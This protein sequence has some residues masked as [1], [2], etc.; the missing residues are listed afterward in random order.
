M[1]KKMTMDE[2]IKKFEL[3]VKGDKVGTWKK[4]SSEEK[5][6]LTD[7]ITDNKPEL[8]S[9]IPELE[10]EKLAEV[11]ATYEATVW[12]YVSGWESHEVSVDTRED[13]DYQLKKIA[14]RYAHDGITFES[15]KKS[16]ELKVERTAKAAEEKAS[17]R[18]RET[19]IIEEAV[20]T[21]E[22]KVIRKYMA[23]CDGSEG[24]ECSQDAITVW[25]MPDGSIEKT[26]VHTF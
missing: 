14:E 17:G 20:R 10:A 1:M 7:Y 11:N 5:E 2:V 8:Q 23:E 3:I 21:G 4:L 9:R 15:A 6:F 18:A 12:F 25:A 22:K 16:Y 26:R 19:E 24:D 13:I